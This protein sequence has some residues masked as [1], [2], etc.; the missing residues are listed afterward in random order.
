MSVCVFLPFINLVY[1]KLTRL[2][3][4]ASERAS[5]HNISSALEAACFCRRVI[6]QAKKQKKDKKQAPGLF[7]PTVCGMKSGSC[8]CCCQQERVGVVNTAVRGGYLYRSKTL[9]LPHSL[10][11]YG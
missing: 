8:G 10:P 4:S 1:L 9:S 5:F 3:D 2:K 11:L 7:L 6:A